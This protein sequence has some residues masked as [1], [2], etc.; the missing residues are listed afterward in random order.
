MSGWAIGAFA[1]CLMAVATVGF[2][3]SQ[4]MRYRSLAAAQG[5]W[6]AD[7]F[8]D[9]MTRQGV[10]RGTSA[11]IRDELGTYYMAGLAPR[12]EDDIATLLRID[13]DELTDIVKRLF[14]RLDLPLP[15][16][17]QTLPPLRTVADLAGYID[18]QP[19]S[20]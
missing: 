18:R 6:T 11:A 13:P 14:D 1:V 3:L 20:P 12:P 15:G 7:D 2:N 19:R 5:N 16:Q 9:A 10:S 8:N 17:P 4:W